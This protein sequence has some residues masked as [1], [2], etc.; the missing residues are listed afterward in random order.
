MNSLCFMRTVLGYV[1]VKES[2]RCDSASLLCGRKRNRLTTMNFIA[3][4]TNIPAVRY[5]SAVIQT[6]RSRSNDL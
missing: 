6:S 5:L 4:R 1:V 2:G 3:V